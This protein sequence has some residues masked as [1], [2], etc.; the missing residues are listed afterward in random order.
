VTIG[1]MQDTLE[2]R[3]W[4]QRPKAD[5]FEKEFGKRLGHKYCAFSCTR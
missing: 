2:P 5:R 1:E 4:D 3:W